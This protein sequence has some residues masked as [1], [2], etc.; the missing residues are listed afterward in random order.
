[1]LPA[2][3]QV[4]T[5]GASFEQ[6]IEDYAAAHVDAVELWLGKLETYLE[7]HSVDDVRRLLAEHEIKAPVAA[8]QGGL[9]T[10]QADA[11]REAWNHFGKRLG[12][13]AELGVETLVV[14]GDLHGP[15]TQQDLDRVAT[16]LDEAAKQ[17]SEA[18]V[19]LALEFQSNASFGNNLQTCAAIVAETGSP[20][21]GICLDAFH[22]YTGPSKLEDLGYLTSENLAHVQ[23]CD[24]S[25]VTREIAADADRILP[26]DGE[27]PLEAVISHLQAI[28]YQGCVSIELM[29]PQLWQVAPQQFG[30]IAI[31]A[32][33]KILGQASMG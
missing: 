14:A 3:S 29:N 7:S 26:G 2:I 1:M 21:L 33:R 9:L 17:A 19:R 20:A 22:F 31:T 13:C 11:R 8:F 10:S 32:L 18:G 15:L 6:D 12:L 27:L 23:L 24:L 30:E 16:S 5:L 25:G 4:C 28:K